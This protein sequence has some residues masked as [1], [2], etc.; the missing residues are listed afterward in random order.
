MLSRRQIIHRKLPECEEQG[1]SFGLRGCDGQTIQHV[2]RPDASRLQ[3][4]DRLRERLRIIA[5]PECR[6]HGCVL[7]P[8]Q[9]GHG[10]TGAAATQCESFCGRQFGQR[11]LADDCGQGLRRACVIPGISG[12]SA[13]N[14]LVLFLIRDRDEFAQTFRILR[15]IFRQ[16]ARGRDPFGFS[17]QRIAKDDFDRG[18]QCR[19]DRTQELSKLPLILGT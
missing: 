3:S 6:Q 2:D 18:E 1:E 16:C 14:D 4:M 7:A 15:S 5:N 8:A 19:C 10:G 9:H 12:Q 11:F 17:S 13:E